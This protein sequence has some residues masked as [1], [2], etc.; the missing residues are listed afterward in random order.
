MFSKV[1]KVVCDRSDT[2]PLYNLRRS[3]VLPPQGSQ[4]MQQGDHRAMR[5][6]SDELHAESSDFEKS[7]RLLMRKFASLWLGVSEAD[8]HSPCCHS[9]SGMCDGGR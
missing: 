7:A 6:H 5:P 8:T 4:A 9:Q 2:L 1:S 3:H